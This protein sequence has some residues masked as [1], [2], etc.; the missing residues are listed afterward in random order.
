M[1]RATSSGFD[2]K[3]LAVRRISTSRVSSWI[4]RLGAERI[5]M[6]LPTTLN[7]PSGTCPIL[8]HFGQGPDR[9]PENEMSKL[10]S[11]KKPDENA[12]PQVSQ[13]AGMAGIDAFVMPNVRAN[14]EMTA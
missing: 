10:F 5:S 8:P 12:V 1:L 6:V 9:H 13:K 11:T 4:V 3:L 7:T 2:C 14:L